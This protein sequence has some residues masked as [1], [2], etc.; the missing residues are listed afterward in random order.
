MSLT[1]P[2]RPESTL[3]LRE[4]GNPAPLHDARR[5]RY[6]TTITRLL[7]A[8]LLASMLSWSLFGGLVLDKR[9]QQIVE[10]VIIALGGLAGFAIAA[11]V[12]WWNVRIE[13]AYSAHL[14]ELSQHLRTLAYHDTLTGLYNRGY[15]YEQLSYEV[16]R[17]QRYGHSVSV[18]LLD[19]NNFKAVN[20]GC[21][22]VAGD[23]LLSLVS[24]LINTQVRGTDVAARYGG[25]EF[26]VILP[27]TGRQAA[28]A[29]A[30]KLTRSI[31]AG[32]TWTTLAGED[33]RLGVSCGVA[34]CPDDG[35]T[36]R[37][38][39]QVADARLYEAKGRVADSERGPAPDAVA[40]RVGA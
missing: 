38:L 4:S 37:H 35:H 25:D 26:A 11:Y 13:R 23:Q 10:V 7:W 31:G 24:Q 34:T 21:G 15:F 30:E 39:L 36:L 8:V 2:N 5:Q 33:L 16:E 17:S 32:G 1:Q 12:R 19:L 22:H 40:E 20:D 6:V 9:P 3:D 14:E 27:E 29:T 18:I 28:E